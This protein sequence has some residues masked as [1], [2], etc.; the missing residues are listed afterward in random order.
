M[1]P[2]IVTA[3][4]HAYVGEDDAAK[5][6]GISVSTLRRRNAEEAL[7]APS[8]IGSRVLWN[9]AELRD[10]IAAGMPAR[11]VWQY[12]KRVLEAIREGIRQDRAFARF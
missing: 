10:W 11:C 1:Q 6:L 2:T 8:R 3:V 7:P 9:V 12:Q 4:D 5:M